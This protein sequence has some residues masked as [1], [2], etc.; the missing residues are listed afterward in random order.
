MKE[1]GMYQMVNFL[2]G[3]Q[4]LTV[5]LFTRA[6]GWTLPEVEAFLVDVRKDI[7]NRNIHSYYYL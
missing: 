7:K 5:A 3:L 4:A 1:V 6:L 2:D